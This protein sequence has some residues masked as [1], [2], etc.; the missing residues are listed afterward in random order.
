MMFREQ[1]EENP[2]G[3]SKAQVDAEVSEHRARLIADAEQSSK[4][5]TSAKSDS[6]SGRTR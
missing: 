6:K 1:L 3:K 5:E 4:A 2:G